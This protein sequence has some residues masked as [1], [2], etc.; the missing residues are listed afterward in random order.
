MKIR[1]DFDVTPKELREFFG[2]P[3]VQ[4]IHE[5]MLAELKERWKAGAEGYDPAVLLKPLLP[6]QMQMF[7]ALQ[8]S[9][10]KGFGAPPE[11]TKED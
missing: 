2:L 1:V 9:L 10:W 7:E 4:E 8:K 11:P 5:E 3:D 6:G